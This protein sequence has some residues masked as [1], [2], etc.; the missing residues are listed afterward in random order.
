M[1]T[2]GSNPFE[3]VPSAIVILIV[4]RPE[5]LENHPPKT[6]TSQLDAKSIRDASKKDSIPTTDSHQKMVFQL[7]VFR[8]MSV[9]GRVLQSLDSSYI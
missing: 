1:H 9:F 5:R 4:G 3:F 7:M 2:C 8:V 6:K